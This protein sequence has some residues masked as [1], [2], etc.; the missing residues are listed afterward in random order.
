M[1]GTPTSTFYKRNQMGLYSNNWSQRTLKNEAFIYERMD[2]YKRITLVHAAFAFAVVLA[3]PVFSLFLLGKGFDAV[4][5]SLLF[6]AFSLSAILTAPL[7]GGISDTWGRRPVILLGILFTMLAY[8]LYY[9]AVDPFTLFLGR[10]L[11]GIGYSAVVLVSIAK[12]ED[13]VAQQKNANKSNVHARIGSSLSVG[14]LGHVLGPLIGGVIAAYYGLGSPFLAA[15]VGLGIVGMWYF[16]QKH[17]YH[18]LPPFRKLTW[19]PIPLWREYLK[20]KPLRGL[21]ALVMPHQFSIAVVFAFLPLFLV[22]HIHL[23]IEQVGIIL[24]V[25]EIPQLMQ[26]LAGKLTDKWGSKKVSILGTTLSG[27][28]MIGFAF[29]STFEVVLITAFVYG[30]GASIL[31]IGT[32]AMLSGIGEKQKRE[33]TYL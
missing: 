13:L 4:T 12:L 21:L 6:S 28:G 23:S 17:N 20:V 33:A 1:N 14:K 19:N 25:K 15:V 24:F 2:P 18:P 8:V 29:A 10:M 31:G 5:L 30:L 9:W 16:F 11:E 7:I 22:E 3:D 32:L 27:I 26:Q